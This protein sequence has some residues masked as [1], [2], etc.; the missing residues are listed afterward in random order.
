MDV[1]SSSHTLVAPNGRPHGQVLL[2]VHV[3]E[4]LDPFTCK[5]PLEPLEIVGKSIF[6]LECT[7]NLALVRPYPPDE[8]THAQGLVLGDGNGPGFKIVHF[9]VG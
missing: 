9:R 4:K 2:L 6:G 8:L 5:G 1:L 3:L 7:S